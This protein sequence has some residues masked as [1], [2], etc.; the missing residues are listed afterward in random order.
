[1]SSATVSCSLGQLAVQFGCGL[2]GDP[3]IKV[4]SVAQLDGGGASL[5]FVASPAYLE[6]LRATRLAAVIVNDRLVA[7]CPVAALVHPNPHATFAGSRPCCTPARRRRQVVHATA[8]IHPSAQ[9]DP[10]AEIGAFVMIGAGAVVG[11]RSRV[12]A[13]CIVGSGATLG[14]DSRIARKGHC[15]R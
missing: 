12:A 1:M 2:R 8:V 11:P 10:S 4:G 14:A 3:D 13:Q 7:D 5:G 9:V 6:Q 15:L